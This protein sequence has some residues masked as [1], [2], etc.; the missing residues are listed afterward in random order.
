MRRLPTA[1]LPAL[2]ALLLVSASSPPGSQAS[3]VMV[4]DDAAPIRETPSNRAPVVSSAPL[5]LLLSTERVPSPREFV[6]VTSAERRRLEEPKYRHPYIRPHS[7][8]DGWGKA[9]VSLDLILYAEPPVPAPGARRYKLDR[10]LTESESLPG[11]YYVAVGD[12][13]DR[14]Q[15][16][17]EAVILPPLDGPYDPPGIEERKSL[18]RSQSEY[19][20]AVILSGPRPIRSVQERI[21]AARVL[22]RKAQCGEVEYVKTI[23]RTLVDRSRRVGDS[24]DTMLVLVPVDDLTGAPEGSSVLW[25][26]LVCIADVFYVDGSSET[27][28]RRM[29]VTWPLCP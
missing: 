15:W 17:G 16:G 19:Q 23:V 3:T 7:F 21:A 10:F 27:I 12:P 25:T 13:G 22:V 11:S 2:G 1:A 5:G 20:I 26:R 14:S 9:R 29:V 24:R 4:V 18:L 6:Q 8:L 28:A